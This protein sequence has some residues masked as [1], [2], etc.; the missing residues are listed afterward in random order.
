MKYSLVLPLAKR[1]L[2]QN[3]V[4]TRSFDKTHTGGMKE[5]EI[6]RE[7]ETEKDERA[8]KR[9]GGRES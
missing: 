8:E 3:M 4:K 1:L 9:R 6:K 5:R 7:R 2:V